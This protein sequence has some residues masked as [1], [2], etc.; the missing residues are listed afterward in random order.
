MIDYHSNLVSALSG[1]LETH[2]EMKLHSGLSVPC[3]SYMENNNYAD[4]E[5]NTIGYSRVSYTVKVWADD[6]KTIQK[7]A[8]EIDQTLRPLGWKRTSTTELYD[9]NSSRIQ[10][11]MIFEALGLE[12]FNGGK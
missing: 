1:I 7:Y 3:I 5:G 8:A 9:Q 11:I 4:A 10:K 12:E 6:I 2:Y